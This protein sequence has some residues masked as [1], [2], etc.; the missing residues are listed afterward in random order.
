MCCVGLGTNNDFCS[1]QDRL[2]L[3]TDTHCAYYAVRSVYCALIQ[4]N[5]FLQRV[6]LLMGFKGKC[7]TLFYLVGV[8]EVRWDKGGTVRAGDYNFFYGK[9]LCG[10]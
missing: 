2:V 10:W 4:V 5:I 8:Q 1:L 6:K 9:G 7:S 3:I